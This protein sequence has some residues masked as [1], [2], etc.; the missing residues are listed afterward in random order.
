MAD[1]WHLSFFGI[2]ASASKFSARSSDKMLLLVGPSCSTGGA[3][4]EKIITRLSYQ[5]DMY[6]MH[7]LVYDSRYVK[8]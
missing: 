3:L 4:Q 1:L 7:D 8:R 6:I 2:P 5:Q